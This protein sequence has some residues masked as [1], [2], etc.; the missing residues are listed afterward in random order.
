MTGTGIP[1]GTGRN[2]EYGSGTVQV[3]VL[4]YGYGLGS[5]DAVPADLYSI[6]VFLGKTLQTLSF[7]VVYYFISILVPH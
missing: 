7:R 6:R 2:F 4:C 5:K 3:T 1:A